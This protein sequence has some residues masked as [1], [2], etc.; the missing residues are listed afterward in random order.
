MH[1]GFLQKS[2]YSDH[3]NQKVNSTYMFIFQFKILISH[4]ASSKAFIHVRE[5]VNNGMYIY[6]YISTDIVYNKQCFIY[7]YIS[8]TIVVFPVF[9]LSNVYS[10]NYVLFQ[11]LLI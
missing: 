8:Y 5:C 11:H 3:V 2:I 7:I 4:F 6:I 1:E 9:V 10:Y